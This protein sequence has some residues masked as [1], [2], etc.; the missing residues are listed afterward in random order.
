MIFALANLFDRFVFIRLSDANTLTIYGI[1]TEDSGS[2]KCSAE[3]LSMASYHEEQIN[4]ES[5]I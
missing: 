1:T 4:V 2:Y 5:M 3:N